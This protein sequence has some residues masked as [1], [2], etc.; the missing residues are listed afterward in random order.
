MKAS[1]LKQPHEL[2]PL[3]QTSEMTLHTNS[4]KL[5]LSTHG[6][7]PIFFHKTMFALRPV[8][9]HWLIAAPSHRECMS[10]QATE[11]LHDTNIVISTFRQSSNSDAFLAMK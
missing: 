4:I 1:L 9:F 3:C 6:S 7:N 8:A 10:Y 5:N 2:Q 11:T